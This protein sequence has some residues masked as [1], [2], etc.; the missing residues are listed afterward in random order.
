MF[1][2]SHGFSHL[3]ECSIIVRSTL[4]SSL[5]CPITL[6][7]RFQCFNYWIIVQLSNKNNAKN[8]FSLLFLFFPNFHSVPICL[9][10]RML[11]L[12]YYYYSNTFS[13]MI[14]WSMF[15]SSFFSIYFL[16]PSKSYDYSNSASHFSLFLFF[17][18]STLS[19]F[20][21]NYFSGFIILR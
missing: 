18:S 11:C 8:I 15:F 3:L 19:Q 6:L 21:K 5:N 9:Q 13:L 7:S 4:M 12:F 17:K 20:F 14:H 2:C 10:I 16:A 1:F